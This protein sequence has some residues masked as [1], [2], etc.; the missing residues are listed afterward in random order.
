MLW[1]VGLM[2]AGK[3]TVGPLVAERLG[4]PFVDTDDL[5]ERRSGRRIPDLF[6][7]GGDAFRALE[8][9]AIAEVAAGATAVVATGG[10][11]VLD[12]AN[13]IVMRRTG[14]VVWLRASA[15]TLAARVGDGGGRPLLSG[16]DPLAHLGALAADRREAYE[17][18]AHEII[19]VDG[20]DVQE[21][22]EEVVTAWH[23]S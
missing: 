7:D 9:D 8:C 12:E 18:A 2:G 22:T 19:D 23:A 1:L 11:A 20:R 4:L 17:A 16:R 13:R 6:T 10:G 21:V 14:I 5:V 3:S 15:A